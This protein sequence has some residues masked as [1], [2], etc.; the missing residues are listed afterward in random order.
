MGWNTAMS[1]DVSHP[2]T[3]TSRLSYSARVTEFC[4]QDT[5]SLQNLLFW[6]IHLSISTRRQSPKETKGVL[7]NSLAALSP[8]PCGKH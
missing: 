7:S 2:S 5:D 6:G 8:D 3:N 1:V 4:R